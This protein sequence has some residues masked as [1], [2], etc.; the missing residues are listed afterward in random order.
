MFHFIC[1]FPLVI[2]VWVV[3]PEYVS[4]TLKKFSYLCETSSLLAHDS[5]MKSI[6]Q[7]MPALTELEVQPQTPLGYSGL[8][9]GQIMPLANLQHLQK[10]SL[11]LSLTE[12]SGDIPTL[13]V[14]LSNF[15]SLQ[16]LTLSWAMW[17]E[18][19]SVDK[20]RIPG[21]MSYLEYSLAAVANTNINIQLSFKHH[22]WQFITKN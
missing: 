2:C 16:F 3:E 9:P 8:T 10:L 20:R 6:S 4:N 1:S 13:I 11:P 17:K 18:S 19:W 15:P 14:V 21:R 7:Y 22:P 12:C 5:M